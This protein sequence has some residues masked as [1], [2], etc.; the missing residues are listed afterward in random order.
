MNGIVKPLIFN[1]VKHIYHLLTKPN[2]LTYNRLYSQLNH[3]KR[4][5]E[6]KITLNQN[7]LLM[8][9][10]ASFLSAYKEIFLEQIYKFKADNMRPKILDLGA[11]IGLSVI[12]FKE[13]YPDAEIVALEADPRIFSYLKNNINSQGYQN[14]ELINKAVWYEN[15]ILNFVSEGADGGQVGFNI[16]N[17]ET[18]K[19]EAVD[20]AKLLSRQQFDF[21]KMDI[22]GA[23]EFVLPRCEGLLNSVQHLFIEYHSKV[24]QKQNLNEILNLLSREEFRLYME[25]PFERSTPFLGL[26]A[27][28]GFDFQIN[29]YAWRE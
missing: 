14:V 11:N 8:P 9:D 3:H 22:E 19:V 1:P 21:V 24:G 5:Q 18:L 23:E 13:L 26:D 7:E 10:A 15:S 29:I 20:I 12:F 2:Y 4:Y 17:H 16:S 25:N 28:A 6:C 27:Y